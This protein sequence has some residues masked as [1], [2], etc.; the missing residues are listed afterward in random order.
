[1]CP[2]FFKLQIFFS[3][4]MIIYYLFIYFCDVAKMVI[5]HKNIVTFRYI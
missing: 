4:N 5:I 3:S 2:I 1:M